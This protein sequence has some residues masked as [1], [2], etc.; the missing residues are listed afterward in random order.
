M[1][2]QV[3]FEDIREVCYSPVYRDMCKLQLVVKDEALVQLS[4][5]NA[6]EGAR[7]ISKDILDLAKRVV[8]VLQESTNI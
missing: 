8:N 1:A 5:Y 7:E 6:V 3:I 4:Y 2:M